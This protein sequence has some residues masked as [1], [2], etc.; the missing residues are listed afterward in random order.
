MQLFIVFDLLQ[1]NHI[2]VRSLLMKKLIFAFVAAFLCIPATA[3]I[4]V[5]DPGIYVAIAP[6]LVPVEQ[7]LMNEGSGQTFFTSSGSGDNLVGS[8]TPITWE[9]VTGF[10]GLVPFFFI[11]LGTPV[12]A[13]GLNQT[14]TNFTGATPFSVS[15][16]ALI[17]NFN[18]DGGT[19]IS[20]LQGGSFTGWEVGVN[21]DASGSRLFN[22]DIINTSPGNS[23]QMTANASPSTGVIHHFVVTYDGSQHAAGATLYVDGISQSVT[24]AQDSLTESAANTQPVQV[25]GRT[26]GTDNL[27]G[28]MADVRIYNV[29]LTSTQVSAIFAA[30]PQ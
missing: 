24:V 15:L 9:S 21:G 22:F 20:T 23:I 28:N 16:W 6:G 17:Q 26:N 7:W 10:P 27:T 14:N 11:S 18:Q 29:Q 8:G 13:T 25:G 1:R 12:T 4:G 2:P 5:A 3:Q 19:F 30:G